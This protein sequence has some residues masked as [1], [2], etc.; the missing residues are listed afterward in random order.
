MFVTDPVT[1]NRRPGTSGRS[2]PAPT[3]PDLFTDERL[4]VRFH[5]D[6]EALKAALS[7]F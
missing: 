6:L 7:L 5:S 2:G 1:V 3:P 4:A